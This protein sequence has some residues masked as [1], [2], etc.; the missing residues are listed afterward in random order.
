M[1]TGVR[2]SPSWLGG[3]PPKPDT[4][5]QTD[6]R[7][8][9]K[10]PCR[11]GGPY[12]FKRLD[13]PLVLHW[14]TRPCADVGK[15][16]L[17]QKLSDVARM[18]V[19]AEPLGDDALE[20][21]APPAHHA[22]FLTVRAGFHDLRELSQ[23]FHRQARLGT[24]RAFVDEALRPRS[25]EAMNPVAQRLAIHAADLRRPRPVH[26]IANRSQRQKTTALADGL[27]SASQRAKLPRRIVFSQSHR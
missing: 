15:A 19:D 2:V 22:I 27:R 12:V 4:L 16:K 21:D 23:L 13:D 26:S 18:K 24:F 6:H 1:R 17:L 20:V 9:R 3:S 25:V 7:R 11:R 10:I 8:S 14:M 5:Q